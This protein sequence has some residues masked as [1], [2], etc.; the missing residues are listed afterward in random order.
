M[1]LYRMHHSKDFG[2]DTSNSARV[3]FYA[4]PSTWSKKDV[5]A[6]RTMFRFITLLFIQYK[7]GQRANGSQ[8]GEGRLSFAAILI[9]LAFQL[10]LA[11]AAFIS[12]SNDIDIY[13][14]A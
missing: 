10:T 5:F 2:V 12:L 11:I 1:S 4:D 14:Y 8:F 9:L 3:H 7:P 13:A 6:F